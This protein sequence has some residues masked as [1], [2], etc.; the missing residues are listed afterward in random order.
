MIKIKCIICDDVIE[1]PR[2][3]Q[4][5]CEKHSCKDEFNVNQ[6]DLWKMENPD[7]VKEMNRKAY[8]QKKDNS[9]QPKTL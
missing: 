3:G 4:L 7:K 5:C 8:K 9:A 6:I 2:V 1:K